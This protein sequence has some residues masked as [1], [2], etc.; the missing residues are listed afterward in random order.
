MYKALA[1]DPRGLV[2]QLSL[3]GTQEAEF[4]SAHKVILF[5]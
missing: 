4:L 2:V 3:V 5:L 1:N